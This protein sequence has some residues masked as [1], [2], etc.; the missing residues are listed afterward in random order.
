MDTADTI[1]EMYLQLIRQNIEKKKQ[2]NI[3]KEL[4][5]ATL[6][7][8]RAEYLITP[9]ENRA[10]SESIARTF[11]LNYTVLNPLGVTA[12]GLAE[13]LRAGQIY[14]LAN[15]LVNIYFDELV[16]E[17]G[18]E[19]TQERSSTTDLRPSTDTGKRR[20]TK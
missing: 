14:E 11:F 8:L 10:W 9:D 18:Q 1:A 13:A 16:R 17:S 6:Q 7:L 4:S 3:A 20:P 19:P 5:P 15:E 12:S 2:E